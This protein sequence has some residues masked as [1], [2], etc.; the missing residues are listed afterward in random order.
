MKNRM[1]YWMDGILLWRLNKKWMKYKALL[2][3]DWRKQRIELTEFVLIELSHFSIE[4]KRTRNET[5]LLMTF[6][7][8]QIC[9]RKDRIKDVSTALK[10]LTRD[11]WQLSFITE[12]MTLR[13]RKSEWREL[14][15]SFLEHSDF[16]G[17]IVSVLGIY[18]RTQSILWR[19]YQE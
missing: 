12:L 18:T 3:L 9:T 10:L 8:T 2:S 15:S 14:K 7:K 13:I 19:A 17:E 11:I 6:E 4:M 1:N 16:K 5:K